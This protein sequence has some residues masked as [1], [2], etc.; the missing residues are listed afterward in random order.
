MRLAALLSTLLACASAGVPAAFGGGPLAGAA[1]LGGGLGP[2]M[3]VG[4][5]LGNAA[6]GN[7]GG[8]GGVSGLGGLGAGGLDHGGLGATNLGAGALGL[9]GLGGLGGGGALLAAGPTVVGVA[10]GPATV[11]GPVSVSAPVSIPGPVATPVASV[12]YVKQPVIKLRYVTRPVT[13]YVRQPVATVTHTIKKIVNYNNAGALTLFGGLSLSVGH[14]TRIVK[15][16]RAEWLRQA[17][18]YRAYLGDQLH[19]A[20]EQHTARL[21]F[22]TTCVLRTRSLSTSGNFSCGSFGSKSRRIARRRS[23]SFTILTESCYPT[24]CGRS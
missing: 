5:G 10:A 1:L 2:A 4:D 14:G 9:G 24:T 21:Q 6:L 3:I 18:V 20:F 8:F 19:N 12:T 17:R 22:R 13:T 7:L 15:I 23:L 11:S 16:L